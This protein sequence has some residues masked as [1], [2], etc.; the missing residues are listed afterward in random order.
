MKSKTNNID[1]KH[2]E[3]LGFELPD[4]YFETSKN[5][6]L[7]KT[8]SKNE[9]KTVALYKRKMVWFAAASIA[10][11][12][13]LTVYKQQTFH[14]IKAIPAIVLD[15]INSNE[16]IDLASDYITEENMLLATL[17]VND[18][19]IEAYINNAFI[20]NVLADEYLDEYIVDELMTDELF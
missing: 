4:N 13:A 18:E 8:S 11:V 10:L 1:A 6:I 19:N 5:E 9:V 20:G 2:K 17:L 16:N 15:S 12:I 3:D 7:L 14:S